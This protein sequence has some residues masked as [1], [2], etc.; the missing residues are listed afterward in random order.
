M[1]KNWAIVIGINNYN[2][3]KFTSLKYAKQDA[4][5]VQ[6][7]FRREANFDEVC[8]FSDDSA[9]FQWK[10]NKIP[11]Q[12]TYGNLISFLHDRFETKPFLSAGDNCWFFFA[13]HGEQH[14]NQDYLMPQDANPRSLQRTAIPVNYVRERLSRSGAD[15]VILIL[16]A[17]RTQVSRG[18]A[19][20]GGEAQQGAIVISSCSPTQKSWEI[21]QLQ[22]GA[23]T[24]ALLEGLRMRGELN[25]A[26]VERLDLH[27]RHRV[28]ELCKKYGKYPE[29]HPRTA[30]DPAD[31]RYFILMP[32]R[33]T[34]RGMQDDINILKMNAYRSL[35]NSDLDA[36][37][38][39]W[40]RVNAAAKGLDIEALE[41]FQKIGQMKAAHSVSP[42][43]RSRNSSNSGS[44]T[45][46][47][48]EV[49]Q[50]V[51]SARSSVTL[52]SPVP[53]S[54]IQQTIPNFNLE[55]TANSSAIPVI[56][57]NKFRGVRAS[58]TGV[59]VARMALKQKR[60]SQKG[61][62]QNCW[63]TQLTI[64]RFLKQELID[65]E[66]L[67]IICQ[68][69]DLTPEAIVDNL[70]AVPSISN[71]QQITS[72]ENSYTPA[73]I[74]T[75]EF[76]VISVNFKGQTIER[77]PQI[78]EHRIDKL[79][80]I[81][82][83][84]VL[85]PGGTFLMGSSETESG[86]MNN[87]KPQHSVTIQPFLIGKYPI[88]Q[89][90]WKAVAAFPKVNRDI[91]LEPSHFKGADRPVE[92]VSWYDAVEFCDRLSQKTG[93]K[94]RL[95][96]EAEWEYAC[97]AGTTTPFH[98][99][100]TITPDVA[101]YDCNY[102]YK[103]GPKAKGSYRKQTNPVKTFSFANAFGLFDMHGNVWE[104]CL[105]Y[106]HENYHEAPTDGS[107]W[108]TDNNNNSRVLRGGSWLNAPTEC[109]SAYRYNWNSDDRVRRFGFRI[110]CLLV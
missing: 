78:A 46:L 36:A 76:E 41:A 2:P 91:E 56:A 72:S 35:A 87:E 20:I 39:L 108:L 70:A 107:A 60:L 90:Q 103:S 106:W 84:I 101:N 22:H 66:T 26:T 71:N 58:A 25:C 51:K 85:I 93:S 3:N 43:V 55:E 96:T 54:K 12:P 75:F 8:F 15:N 98:F 59:E 45:S 7:F 88:T 4:E 34:Q 1:S 83:E 67:K 19:G 92:Q 64:S 14:A 24:Y 110:V 30:V 49:Q 105:D 94:Y 44:R 21:D 37:E 62:A 69:L 6:D 86:G 27:L 63:L 13:G 32:D 16:D 68:A 33:G 89:A 80:D 57:S 31:K 48:A 29:Q 42:S 77:H 17:C 38:Q 79:G 28:P 23:F 74:H 40:I 97:R 53:S 61:L 81:V 5:S 95:P 82:L 109:R 99:G 104:W 11:T 18:A 65:R 50:S 52:S 10:G 9:D 47:P 100:E 102:S 73:N